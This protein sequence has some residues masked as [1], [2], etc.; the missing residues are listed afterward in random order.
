VN[1]SSKEQVVDYCLFT[2]AVVTCKG[3]RDGEQGSNLSSISYVGD[4]K[5]TG[6]QQGAKAEEIKNAIC[7]CH[8]SSL[9]EKMGSAY[10][11]D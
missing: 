3:V 8:K 2:L 11:R 5:N 9:D 1:I 10:A 7:F 4:V 6:S